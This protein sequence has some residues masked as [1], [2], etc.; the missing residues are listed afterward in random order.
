VPHLGSILFYWKD[1]GNT[2][3]PK[4]FVSNIIEKNPGLLRLLVGFL[5]ESY[6]EYKGIQYSLREHNLEEIA[7]FA[8]LSVIYSKLTSIKQ[9]EPY[10]ISEGLEK[11]AADDF[12]ELYKLNES[13]HKGTE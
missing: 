9:N 5:T 13:N 1:Y 7:E 2:I 8:D 11:I 4:G 3:E 10:L 12:I 6:D